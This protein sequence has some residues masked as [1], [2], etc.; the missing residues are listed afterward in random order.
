M[1]P[2]ILMTSSA[3]IVLM[4]VATLFFKGPLERI[5]RHS[6]ITVKSL[7]FAMEGIDTHEFNRQHQPYLDYLSQK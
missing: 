4:I 7:A 5:K 6:S 2:L 1:K 3:C